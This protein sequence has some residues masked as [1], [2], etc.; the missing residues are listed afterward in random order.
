[1]VNDN[2]QIH[3]GGNQCG[4]VEKLSRWRNALETVKCCEIMPLVYKHL[5]LPTLSIPAPDLSEGLSWHLGTL[6]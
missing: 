1:M 5:A 6:V 2:V 4:I 3:E